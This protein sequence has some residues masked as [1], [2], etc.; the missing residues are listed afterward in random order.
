MG[1][2]ILILAGFAEPWVAWLDLLAALRLHLGVLAALLAI[3]ALLVGAGWAAITSAAVAALAFFTLGPLWHPAERPAT[4]DA[5]SVNVLFANVRI[6]NPDVDALERALV[7]ADANV[8]VVSEGPELL[9]QAGGA[10]ARSYPYAVAAR[11]GPVRTALFSRLPLERERV[12]RNINLG[13]LAAGAI[14]HI[15]DDTRLGILG[16]HFFKWKSAS[17]KEAQ[18]RGLGWLTD[19]LKQPRIVIGDFNASVWSTRVSRTADATGTSPL[20][21]W[22]TTWRGRYPLGLPA[23]VG[24]QIDHLLASPGIGVR[25][26]RTIDIPGSDHYGLFAELLV[27]PAPPEGLALSRPAARH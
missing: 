27:P 20:G 10:L 26:L 1:L 11:P 21:G 7:A 25:A 2:A 15:D 4:A 6:E 9:G 13:P 19:D 22:R 16:V 24:Q 18:L 17:G 3:G 14:V 5:R 8:I 23:L 12:N